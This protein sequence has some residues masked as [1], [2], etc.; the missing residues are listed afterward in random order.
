MEIERKYLVRTLPEDLASRR[1]LHIEQAYI[2]TSPVIRIRRENDTWYL[3]CKGQGMLSR[4]ECNLPMTRETSEH[5]LTKVEGTVLTKDRY[6]IPLSDGLCAELDCFHGVWE[7]LQIIE[8]E[9]PDLEQA[10]RF[11]PPAW[12]GEDVTFDPRY[13]N[14]WMSRHTPTE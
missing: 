5:L 13:H 3:T 11:V 4:E 7:G 2:C 9:F 1:C 10:E 6:L 8:V 12:F 14:S